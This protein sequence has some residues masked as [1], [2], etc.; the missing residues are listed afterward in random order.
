MRLT[1]DL[2][3]LLPL[4]NFLFPAPPP[5]PPRPPGRKSE[6]EAVRS[7]WLLL[8]AAPT[9]GE[10]EGWQVKEAELLFYSTLSMAFLFSLSPIQFFFTLFFPL[11]YM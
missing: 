1:L 9:G 5:P 3:R 11:L 2:L 10:G 8:S 6:G 4:V 7:E